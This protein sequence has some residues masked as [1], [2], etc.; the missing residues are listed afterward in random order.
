[1]CDYAHEQGLTGRRVA[2]EELFAPN[3]AEMFRV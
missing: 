2:V 3:T 1:M